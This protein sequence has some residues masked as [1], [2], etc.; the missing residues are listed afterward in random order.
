[1]IIRPGPAL[2]GFL[3]GVAIGVMGLLSVVEL[4]IKNAIDNGT[5]SV[6]L[7]LA[8][9]AG[10][11]YFAHPY[12]PDFQAPSHSHGGGESQAWLVRL[13]EPMHSGACV[14]LPRGVGLPLQELKE[15]PTS[16]PAEGDTSSPH[17]T[18]S[19]SLSLLAGLPSVLGLAHRS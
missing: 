4:W 19:G 5:L 8:I 16:R 11:Y 12:F 10:L 18:A 13:L 14:V 9:G 7:A 15:V 6:T 3:L 1:M 17:S 2:L